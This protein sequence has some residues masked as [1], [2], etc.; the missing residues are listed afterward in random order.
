[1]NRCI[2]LTVIA[3]GLWFVLVAFM[4][5]IPVYAQMESP[6]EEEFIIGSQTAD[7]SE[8]FFSLLKV[9]VVLVFIVALIYFVVRFLARK[10]QLLFGKRSVRVLSG[11]QLAPGKSLQI[12][13][14]GEYIYVIGV[15]DDVRLVD[16]ITDEKQVAAILS[17][18]SIPDSGATGPSIGDW[19]RRL[20]RRD[21]EQ[22]MRGER[23]FEEMFRERLHQASQDERNI[24]QLL[25]EYEQD[26]KERLKR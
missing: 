10:N 6:N 22:P 24:E 23:S 3:A 7:S 25:A 20:L 8:L 21:Q 5:A 12:I 18:L 26:E 1:M 15:G 16:R 9:I 11:V 4:S 14:L 13:E 19:L 17:Q 2:R